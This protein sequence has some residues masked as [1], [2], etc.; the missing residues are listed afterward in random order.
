MTL[1]RRSIIGCALAIIGLGG[2][3]LIFGGRLCETAAARRAAAE[4]NS[5]EVFVLAADQLSLGAGYP[6]SEAI[7]KRAGLRVRPCHSRGDRFDC[8]PWAGVEQARTIG[9]FQFEVRWGFAA[10]PLA[11][12][13]VRT[14]Y[15]VILGLVIEIGQTGEWAA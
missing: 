1:R 4:I 2:F 11:G 5:G 12:Y 10:A 14:R 3:S 15:L 6:G 9:P 7:L 13:G 8:F